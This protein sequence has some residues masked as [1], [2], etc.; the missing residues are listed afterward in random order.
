MMKC[1]KPKAVDA[2]SRRL[3]PLAPTGYV[4]QAPTRL[5]TFPGPDGAGALRGPEAGVGGAAAGPRCQGT[6]G[7]RASRSPGC[8]DA[9][10]RSVSVDFGGRP[11]AAGPWLGD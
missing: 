6:R 11:A 9:S 3:F 8:E 5:G 2:P 1:Y 4:I 7:V 10:H